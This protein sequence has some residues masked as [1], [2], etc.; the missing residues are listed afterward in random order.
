MAY[1]NKTTILHE[2]K[3][4]KIKYLNHSEIFEGIGFTKVTRNDAEKKYLLEIKIP[5]TG[6]EI[7]V[8]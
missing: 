5:D 8:K 7:S 1:Q 3:C 4:S 2:I 6:F